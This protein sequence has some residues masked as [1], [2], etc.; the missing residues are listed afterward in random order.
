MKQIL[1]TD[2]FSYLP[3][4][5]QKI[6]ELGCSIC[7]VANETEDLPDIAKSAE[8]IVCNGLFLYHDI[9]YF[10]QLKFIQLTSAGLDR[11]P[12]DV[13]HERNIV[14]KNARGVYSTPMAEWVMMR[15][16]EYYKHT[17][18][19]ADNQKRK[20]WIKDRELREIAGTRVA[21][22]GAGNVG[23]E[24]ARRFNAFGSEVI[25]F[26]PYCN[27][28]PFFD[29]VV[30]VGQLHRRLSEFDIVILTAPLNKDT[31]HLMSYQ[32]LNQLKKNAILVNIARGGLID[33]TAL[34]DVL[35]HRTDLYAALDVFEE[36]PLPKTHP[37]WNLPNVSISPHN[38]FV[39]NGNN[40]RLFKVIYQ[41][42]KE[43][44][45]LNK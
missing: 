2:A 25:G 32:L 40:E 34:T 1:L 21:V 14:L 43:Y 12:I 8:M 13:I 19:F 4:D 9:S 30:D 37:L 36:E 28:Q 41:N 42:L 17:L 35:S 5:F 39:G 45:E 3:K 22:I 18:A 31:Y 10:E 26:D 23:Q 44:I 20:E 11:V 6:E 15:V 29:S 33:T 24:I 16:L 27:G 7:Y 38:S